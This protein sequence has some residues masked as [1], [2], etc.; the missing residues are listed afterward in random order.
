MSRWASRLDRLRELIG[1]GACP[2]C[3]AGGSGLLRF[4]MFE[5]GAP[6]PAPCAACGSV[7]LV[8]SLKL[9]HPHDLPTESDEGA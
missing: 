5:E 8:F 7:P 6:E 9:D 2:A 1:E 4:R 3:G